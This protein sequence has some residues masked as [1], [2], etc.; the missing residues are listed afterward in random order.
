MTKEEAARVLTAA[1]FASSVEDSVVM[2]KEPVTDKAMT[3]IRRLLKSAG[4]DG[5]LG[6]RIRK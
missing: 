2:I 1:G 6:R 4:Y 5:S 3:E